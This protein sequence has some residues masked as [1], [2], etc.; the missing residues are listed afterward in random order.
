MKK[1]FY[2]ILFVGLSMLFAVSCGHD[3][4][5]VVNPRC[6]MQENPVGLSVAAPHLSWE[7]VSG[8]RGVVQRG[9]R[10]LVASSEEN[11][12]ANRG[13][14]WDSGWVE[15]DESVYIPY[16]GIPLQSRETCFWKVR[17]KTNEG[18]SAW[19]QPAA[20]TMGFTDT[21]AWEAGWI[22]LERSFDGDKL[23][24]HTR[25]AARYFRKEFDSPGQVRRAMLYISGLGLYEAYV[26][27]KRIGT[28]VLAQA[29]TDY[30]KSVLYNVFDV[31][32]T[33]RP[34]GNALGVVL[35]NGRYFSPRNPGMRH[36]GFP[37]MLLQLELEYADGTCRKVVSDDSW[38]VTAAGPIRAN[39]EFDGEEYDAR[40]EMPGWNES[41]YAD[42]A[43]L[44]AEAVA[45]PG[46]K[47]A[48]QANPMIEIM[49]TV[50]PVAID[51]I[52][53][54]V[55]I[56]D[57]GQ[58]MVGWLSM[59][60]QGKRGQ[61][62]RLR[63]AETLEPDGS[64]YMD[65]LREAEVTDT[66]TIADEEEHMWEPAFTYHGFRY[67]EITGY[68]GTPSLSDFEGRVVYDRMATTGS[69]RTSNA[70]IN[71]I[72][73]NAYWGIRGNYR[74]MPTDCPQR[75]E[76]QGWLGDRTAGALGESY[77][78]DNGLLYAKWLQDIED[79]QLDNGALSD[80]APNYWQ[81]Y[82]DDVTW[83]SAYIVIA[84]MLYDRFG[85]MEPIVKHYGSM[86]KW[87]DHMRESHMADY[88]IVKDTYGDWCMPPESPELIH[89]QDPARK[90]DGALLSTATYYYLLGIMERFAQLT[91]R[92]EDAARF[93]RE[94]GFVRDAYN[95]KFFDPATAGY[96]NNTVT[97]NL[98]SLV[99]GLVPGEYA[100][101]VFGHVVDKTL[102][103]NGGHVSTGLVG[104]RHLMQGLTRYGRAD[105]AYRLA[106]NRDYPSWGYMAEQGATTI[107][108]LWNGDTADPAMNSANHVMLLGD[109][110]AWYY[111]DLA[112]IA[113]APGA[114][115]FHEIAMKPRPVAGLDSVD[116]SYRSVR[117]VIKS[118]WTKKDGRFEW[119]ITVPANTS[120][121]VY[122]PTGDPSSV[123]EG[124]RPARSA[125]GVNL[126]R[127]EPGY[128]VFET[129][130]G[131]YRFTSSFSHMC[132]NLKSTDL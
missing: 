3:A 1:S 103:E 67:V 125:R 83:P 42:G 12:A 25:L 77:V 118:R 73:R 14:K 34:G 6:E 112:G 63:F 117:G 55:H 124:D 91:G 62:V 5:R 97:A 22:G 64:L 53:P 56:L 38:R 86:K 50:R 87:M 68:P 7:L 58:N 119:E 71:R 21:G 37:K 47:L 52:A 39:N 90:T 13:D 106:T 94:A 108:E 18:C 93:H 99:Y 30:D 33:I 45:A 107:W 61:T 122:V 104:I 126:L 111:E 72:Y 26:N 19:S 81:I 32:E 46:G 43:W 8:Q 130:S 48:V 4:V 27:G 59:R 69:F 44:Q 31:T 16:G 115:A 9:Y 109:L 17:V 2:R 15:S 121:V 10:I 75:D 35:G 78:F 70:T 110:I 28:Q 57:M 127:T 49:D 96:G 20:W 113:N 84:Q 60:V 79:T 80:V 105:V 66:Y 128:A 98:L 51:R 41:G 132:D 123:R 36:F 131:S 82:N 24:G 40:M 74:G 120:A 116:A 92:A 11:L 29:P 95:R 23:D 88:I 65:N 101:A 54:G 89:S 100:Q 85:N 76:R 129:G 114:V 102:G